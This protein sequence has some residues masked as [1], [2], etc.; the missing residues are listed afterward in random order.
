M[1]NTKL[2]W[3]I[4][5]EIHHQLVTGVR[6]CNLATSSGLDQALLRFWEIEE[7]P[8]SESKD[9][10]SAENQECEEHFLANTSLLDSNRVQRL[11][12]DDPLTPELGNRWKEMESELPYLK[13]IEIQRYVNS[14]KGQ[15]IE[16]HGFSDA[17]Q[18]AYGC[19]LYL[20]TINNRT[21]KTS[22]HTTLL[23]AKSRVAPI[24]TVI[25][26]VEAILNSRP[27]TASTNDPN[28]GEAI[29]PAHLLIGTSL[30]ALPDQKISEKISTL[31]QYQRITYLKQ[32]LWDL[33][34]R[35]YLHELQLR[36][37]WLKAESNVRIGQLVLVHE[38]NLPPQQWQLARI[39]S[40]I[41]GS[42]GRVRVVDLKINN[43]TLRR[44]IHKVAPLPV[45]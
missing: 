22:Y 30:K 44:P 26:E 37:K 14:V 18:R 45:D 9:L 8:S 2:G 43:G 15:P 5:G 12:W 25:I 36:S 27:L 6:S 35:D 42:D 13:D 23:I 11:G 28:D 29:T 38:D 40:A 7:F 31:T 34:R 4:G 21:G 32:R 24:K 17:S 3:I 20:R 10:L 19:S 1:V 33:W 41:P 16:I 39:T